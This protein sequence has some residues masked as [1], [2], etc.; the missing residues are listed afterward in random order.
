ML[1]LSIFFNLIKAI[2]LSMMKSLP[3]SNKIIF[4]RTMSL[5]MMDN[6]INKSALMSFMFFIFFVGGLINIF[7][8]ISSSDCNEWNNHKKYKN[9]INKLVFIFFTLL[10]FKMSLNME[11]KNSENKLLFEDNFFLF[12]LFIMPNKLMNYMIMFIL[13]FMMMMMIWMMKN[14]NGA[15]SRKNN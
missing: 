14:N 7:F 12:N 5:T 10:F 11:S 13:F 9:K 4:I 8:Y 1:K 6:L 3:S 2:M 15:T